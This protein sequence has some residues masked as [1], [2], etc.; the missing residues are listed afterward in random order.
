MNTISKE[1]SMLPGFIGACISIRGQ[2]PLFSS[3]PNTYT[4]A[5]IEESATSIGRMMQMAAVKGLSPQTMSIR[6]NKFDIIGMPLENDAL[7][8]ILCESGSNT[9]LVATTACMLGPEFEKMIIQAAQ[10]KKQGVL[11]TEQTPPAPPTN[12]I[13]PKTSQA[14]EEIKQALYDTVG[15]IADMVFSDCLKLWTMNSPADISRIF[16]FIGLISTEIDNPELFDEFK[17]KISSLL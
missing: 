5:M 3:L 16:E 6:Y 14:L 8:L 15:P 10:P 12:T 7:L 1:F 11:T 9:S 4:D 17:E 2:A 13:S